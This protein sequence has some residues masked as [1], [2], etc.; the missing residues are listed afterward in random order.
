[1]NQW[2]RGACCA[3][4][5][6]AAAVCCDVLVGGGEALPR[7]I[8]NTRS[9][10]DTCVRT[11]TC[12]WRLSP[13]PG[14]AAPVKSSTLRLPTVHAACKLLK[15]RR[16]PLLCC[17]R[18]QLW[19]ATAGYVAQPADVWA[20]WR[21]HWPHLACPPPAFTLCPL[22]HLRASEFLIHAAPTASP[23]PLLAPNKERDCVCVCVCVC[24]T[25]CL[26]S[27]SRSPRRS[28]S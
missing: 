21:P 19:G 8:G 25:P 2:A 18:C 10:C 24:S 9:R 27:A 6:L 4:Q 16:V 20:S 3:V 13:R 11:L 26:P 5:C 1:M 14:A 23:P 12:Y 28:F 7:A 17:S 15:R 22:L